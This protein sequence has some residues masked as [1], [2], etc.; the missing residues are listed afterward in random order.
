MPRGSYYT[1]KLNLLNCPSCNYSLGDAINP[2]QP[3]KC[4][5]CGSMIILTDWT[6]TGQPICAA[7]GVVNAEINR[8]C[9]ACG[10]VLQV[11]CPFCYSL[12]GITEINCKNCGANLQRAWS[13]QKNWLAEKKKHDLERKEALQ[14]AARSQDAYLQR[15]LLRLDDPQNHPMAIPSIRLF[16]DQAVEPLIKLLTSKDPDAR[17]GAARTLGDIGNPRAISELV[18]VLDDP[19]ASVRYWAVDALGKLHADEAVDAI[20]KLLKDKQPS[21]KQRA[22]D[23]LKQMGDR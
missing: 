13:R 9:E 14:E 23:V 15:L 16:G 17:F 22:K 7:C 6:K 18:K 5:A 8:F 20:R 4:P 12:N 21:I 1:M 11:G 3:F 19:D 10:A 2:N